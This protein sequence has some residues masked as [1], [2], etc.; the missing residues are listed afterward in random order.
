MRAKALDVA[1]RA[2]PIAAGRARRARRSTR[3][4]AFLAWLEDHNFT[5]LGYRDYE[6]SDDDGER[7][8]LRAVPGIR[9]RHPA[10][11]RGARAASR[12]LRQ[13]PARACARGRSSPTCSTSR[14]PTR[15]PP[16][17][18]RPT[19]TTSASSASTPRANVIGER[20][21]LGLYTHTAYQR[22]PA[23]TSRSCAARSTRCSSAPPSRTAATTRRRSIEIL[24]THPR[25]ELFQVSAD[26]LFE[27]AM[28][29]LAPRRAPAGAA[30]RAPRPL[31]PLP[32]LPRLRPARPLQHREPPPHRAIL[33]DAYRRARPSTTRR[34]SPSRSSSASTTWSTPSP[35]HGPSP[36]PRES[37]AGSS[38]RRARGPTTS[39][40]R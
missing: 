9:P 7:A 19:S 2:R 8:A 18:A 21:F 39:S 30:V 10:P 17:T 33:R 22:Q 14:R 35:A 29:I 31:R 16:S 15:A 34:A 5:F 12:A 37:S 38:P 28:G 4:G 25:D 26:E 1:A 36:T 32:L 13:A 20:R 23:R 24:E 11:V 3:R 40:R 27:I 6:S